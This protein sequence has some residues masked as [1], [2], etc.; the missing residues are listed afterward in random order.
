[1]ST[2]T[3]SAL[4]NVSL[5]SSSSPDSSRSPRHENSVPRSTYDPTSLTRIFSLLPSPKKSWEQSYSS[6]QT[7]AR[8][9]CQR[10]HYHPW[11]N[12]CQTLTGWGQPP[13]VRQTCPQSMPTF[14]D[15]K[16]ATQ[17]K[18]RYQFLF[19]NPS[20]SHKAIRKVCSTWREEQFA[21]AIAKRSAK[22]AAREALCRSVHRQ[23][24]ARGAV[25]PAA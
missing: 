23:C 20:I 16:T 6:F 5:E 10:V 13:P 8:S 4:L 1:M 11:C 7:S 19:G 17:E 25:P 12:D 14:G 22:M 21:K 24:T 15:L 9:Q 18:S 3:T 2:T